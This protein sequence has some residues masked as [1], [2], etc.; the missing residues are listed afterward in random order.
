MIKMMYV[1]DYKFVTEVREMH[2]K[3]FRKLHNPDHWGVFT[4]GMLTK[5]I[6]VTLSQGP[7]V[8]IAGG[9]G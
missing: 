3:S 7:N 8:T 4:M 6:L 5:D 9:N 2:K 1:H